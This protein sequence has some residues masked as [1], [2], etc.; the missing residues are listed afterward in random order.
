M[1]YNRYRAVFAIL[2]LAAGN[3]D[4]QDKKPTAPQL[5]WEYQTLGV[6]PQSLQ[7]DARGKLFLYAALKSGGIRRHCERSEAIQSGG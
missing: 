2:V 4:A 6:Q 7:R 1:S 3:S 5:V